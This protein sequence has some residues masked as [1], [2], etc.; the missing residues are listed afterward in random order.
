LITVSR[1]K[2]EAALARRDELLHHPT[3]EPKWRESYY[4]NWVDL[5]NKVSGFSTIGITPN[6]MKRELVLALFV[7][8]QVE[9]YYQEPGLEKYESDA[10]VMLRDDRL[11]YKLIRPLREWQITYASRKLRF[12][13]DFRTRFPTYNFAT[14]SSGSWHR[15]FEASGVISGSIQYANGINKNLRGYG[16]RDKSWGQRD[17]FRFDKWFAGQFQ[18]KNWACAFRKD[19]IRNRIDLSGYIASKDGSSPLSEMT[20]DTVDDTDRFNTPLSSK[21]AFADE[22]GRRHIIESERIGKNTYF[23]F[24]RSFPG[25]YTELFEQMVIMKD[26]DTGEIGSGMAEYLRTIKT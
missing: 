4:F 6:E 14:D 13:L 8:N 20:I 7:D 10:S 24:A 22:K 16:Q 23:R 5:E 11:A 25:G 21:Y 12:E 2:G 19:H 18:F 17:W 26:K 9:V 15:H 1:R 3:T